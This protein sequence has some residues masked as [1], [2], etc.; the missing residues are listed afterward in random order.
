M[1]RKALLA[2]AALLATIG[3][4]PV[5]A[6]APSIQQ[7]FDAKIADTKASMM[8]DPE[9]ALGAARRASAIAKSL[10]DAQARLAMI[11]SACHSKN[12]KS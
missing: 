6:A 1:A 3:S 8:S 11:T 2:L 10:P 7:A 4:T 9:V 5:A 12:S